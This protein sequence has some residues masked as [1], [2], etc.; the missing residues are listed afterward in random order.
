[1]PKLEQVSAGKYLLDNG[2]LFEINRT[3][4]HPIGMALSVLKN[5]R[6]EYILS[7]ALV[8]CSETPTGLVHE[9]TAF[10][11]GRSKYRKFTNSTASRR[12]KLRHQLLGFTVQ[13]KPEQGD[14]VE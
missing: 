7:D 2:L 10:V 5:E 14:L 1:V 4:L 12:R 13:T 11:H 8:D 9:S 6:G 3:I